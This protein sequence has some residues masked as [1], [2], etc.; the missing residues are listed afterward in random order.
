MFSFIAGAGP[1]T[2]GAVCHGAIGPRAAFGVAHVVLSMDVGG[3]ERNVINQVREGRRLG[4]DVSIVCIER[5]G[6][7]AAAAESLGARVV[8]L[9]KPPG[10][11]PRIGLR[12]R[13]ALKQL[14]ATI[15]HSHQVGTMFYSG[16]A[17][18]LLPGTHLVHTAHGREAYA[19]RR[20]SC[21][22]GRLGGLR[23]ERFF[24]LTD[25]IAR[26]VIDK[27]V[28]P[29]HKVRLIT[30]GIETSGFE[31]RRDGGR[32]RASL[33]IPPDAQVIGT[34]GRLVPVK[35]HELLF[36]AFARVRQHRPRARLLVVGDGPLRDSLGRLASDGG[37]ADSVHFAGYQSDVLEYLSLMDCFALTSHSEGMPQAVLEA[38]VLGVP[39]IAS[40]VGGLP[41]AILDGRT[42]LLFAS[43]DEA[44][45]V[46]GLARL[47]GNPAYAA[48]LAHGGRARIVSMYDVSRMAREYHHHYLELM[49]GSRRPR[50]AADPD[51]AAAPARRN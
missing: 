2:A 20:R 50:P 30:N 5:P 24:C 19:D 6:T 29:G 49:A 4:Q 42:G 25:D 12:L 45:L 9:R 3:S 36:R 16:I 35:N 37:I 47:L 34:V 13:D 18:P 28:V 43:G 15:V 8:C 46:S 33:G 23:V 22:L 44:A 51:P 41:D 7:L 39:V 40:R 10:V 31:N 32:L 1:D 38:S 17:T 14:G 48:A 26:E 21:W 27:R 11:R